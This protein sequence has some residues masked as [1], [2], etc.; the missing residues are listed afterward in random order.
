ML[1][2]D[3]NLAGVQTTTNSCAP[4]AI[5]SGPITDALPFNQAHGAFDDGFA[6]ASIG[7]AVRLIL[8]NIGGARPGETD[9]ATLGQP[10]RYSACVAERT[11]GNPWPPF[12][13]QFGVPDDASAVTV[14]A[15]C[16]PYPVLLPEPAD[17]MLAVLCQSLPNASANYFHAA[18]QILLTLSPKPAAALAEA[19]L[20]PGSLKEL[21]Y[22]ESRW[23]VG[24]LRRRGLLE[25]GRGVLSAYW[26]YPQ[27]EGDR[28]ADL[29][30]LGDDDTLPL[31]RSPEDIHILVTGAD[32]Q[33]WAAVLAGWG[34]YGGSARSEQ[35]VVP[36]GQDT[37]RWP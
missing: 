16:G 22:R 3:F 8:R 35:L 36:V 37:W 28:P 4:L 33:W 34:A 18:G 25:P 21:L 6:N 9:M 12:H 10:A 24:D 31:V 7:R 1:D 20:D 27:L 5:V 26:G 17:H 13:R 11:E 29:E 19:G 14:F 32:N 15:C 2:E 23:Q 30:A